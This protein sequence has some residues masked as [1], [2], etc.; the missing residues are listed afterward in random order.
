MSDK[1]MNFNINQILNEF[2]KGNKK[3]AF[4]KLK[5]F[6]EKNPENE[7]AIYNFGYMAESL[8]LFNIAIQNY[9]KAISINKKNW[10]AIFNLYIIYIKNQKYETALK[11]INKVLEIKV[12]Y[13]PALR[14]KALVLYYM[15][16]PDEGLKYINSSLNQNSS[17]YIA[18]NTLGLI[19]MA[20]K[21][22]DKAEAVFKKAISIKSNY[23]P[24]YNNLGRNYYLINK[25]ELAMSNFKMALKLNPNFN[26]AKN[27]IAN[28]LSETGRY[29]KAIEYYKSALSEGKQ[30]SKILYN[31]GVAFAYLKE[32]K[33][34]EEYYKESFK[35]NPDD[36]ELKKNYSYLLLT[37]QKYKKA[38]IL[39]E[40]RLGL[41]DF[42]FKNSY[43]DIIKKYLW[44]GEVLK[45]NESLLVIKEQGIG[46]EII[47]SS[48]YADL[49]A[50]YPNCKIETD[51][52]LVSLFSRSFASSNTFVPYSFYSKSEKKLKKFTK[53]IYAGSLGKI[54][55]N[56]ISDFPKKS[57]LSSDENKSKKVN[58]LLKK[59]NNKIK[60][61]IAWRSK[62]ELLGSD[63]SINLE[64]LLP[65]LKIN[66]FSFI[67]LQYGDTLDEINDFKK[68][69]NINIVTLKDVDLYNDFESIS[70]LLIN[71]D[72][73]ITVSNSTAHL[74]AALGVPTWLIKPKNHAV[75]HYWNQP[76]NS[77]PWYPSVKLYPYFE[78]WKK[79]IQEIKQ[80]L[81]NKFK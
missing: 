74:A 2:Q 61:G 47:F 31:I 69:N 53:V 81:I 58:N 57:F 14:D 65:I 39:H 24:S 76:T 80:D 13:Q 29:S 44:K 60:I 37:L 32:F 1:N 77:T 23:F 78:G 9:K 15:N 62:R 41:N 51:E 42:T 25:R 16:K 54:Y 8:N 68:K 63:K 5:K 40:G 27:N 30:K 45:K 19:Y 22:Y 79:T 46:D 26:E 3:I 71:L 4:T 38:W 43:F 50:K 67:N 66:K 6:I 17:D 73:F 18:I 35:I 55:R 70:A 52:R 7:I 72:L 28:I 21:I 33:K 34:A 75:F 10:R 56:K 64:L 48:M 20:M 49:I 11:L 36:E 59:L 12:N